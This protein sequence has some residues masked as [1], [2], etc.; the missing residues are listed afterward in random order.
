MRC[1]YCG[2]QLPLLK[3]LT[4]GGEFCSEAH[5]QKYQEEYN[6]LAL[7]RLLQTQNPESDGAGRG[8]L[9]LA[10]RHPALQA[11]RLP[12]RALEAPKSIEAPP[13]STPSFKEGR[14]PD[15][16]LEPLPSNWTPGA[17]RTQRAL[18]PPSVLRTPPPSATNLG[19]NLTNLTNDAPPPANE[20]A[21]PKPLDRNPN[22]T[23]H[24][25]QG[26]EFTHDL[27]KKSFPK[28]DAFSFRPMDPFPTTTPAVAPPPE[29]PAPVVPTILPSPLSAR[30]PMREMPGARE[31]VR[32]PLREPLRE[33]DPPQGTF[34][35]ATVNWADPPPFRKPEQGG[36]QAFTEGKPSSDGWA[37]WEPDIQGG[38]GGGLESRSLLPLLG[39]PGMAGGGGGE[40]PNAVPV[41]EEEDQERIE[42]RKRILENQVKPGEFKQTVPRAPEGL[43]T[44][45]PI[46]PPAAALERFTVTVKAMAPTAN[47]GL[48]LLDAALNGEDLWT[49]WTMTGLAPLRVG[50]TPIAP[51]D[52]ETND[53]EAAELSSAATDANPSETKPLPAPMP[54]LSSNGISTVASPKSGTAVASAKPSEPAAARLPIDQPRNYKAA[55]ALK[56]AAQA[57]AV[58][59]AAAAKPQNDKP[60]T[61]RHEV[62]VDL[63]VLGIEEDEDA[64]AEILA[65]EGESPP[66]SPGVS[67]RSQRRKVAAR[68]AVRELVSL[69]HPP[70]SPAEPKL[71]HT[72]QSQPW[73]QTDSPSIRLSSEPLRPKIVF[74]RVADHAVADLTEMKDSNPVKNGSALNGATRNGA[75]KDRTV[76]VGAATAL[77]MDP[78]AMPHRALAVKPPSASSLASAWSA[79]RLKKNETGAPSSAPGNF[80][81]GTPVEALVSEPP[82]TVV[83]TPRIIATAKTDL[84]GTHIE[85]PKPAQPAAPAAQ[86]QPVERKIESGKAV[87]STPVSAGAKVDVPKPAQ[88]K[89]EPVKAVSAPLMATAKLDA[90][91][92]A[93]PAVAIA[94]AQAVEPKVEPAQ[95]TAEANT[96]EPPAPR[97]AA[98][99]PAKPETE[100][101]AGQTVAAAPNGQT[102]N[103]DS[104][105]LNKVEAMKA[106]EPTTVSAETKPEPNLKPAPSNKKGSNSKS[107]T[108]SK[109]GGGEGKS[110]AKNA[111]GKDHKSGTT[112]NAA[113]LPT[114]EP[115]PENPPFEAPILAVSIAKQGSFWANLPI[116][117]KL[118]IVLAVTAGIG[119]GAWM[120]LK[121]AHSSGSET[122]GGK[123]K[124][125]P[126]PLRAGSSLM[127]NLPGGWSPD[128]GGDLNRK[129]N[130]TISFYRP[131]ANH[132]DYR[133][134]FDGQIDAKGLGWVFRAADPKNYYA[135]KIELVRTGSDSGTALTHFSMVDGIESQKHF[136]P[137]AKPLRTGVSFHVRLDV[138][139]DEFSAYINDE[140]I[141]VW[142]DDR[143]PKGGI[144]LMTDQGER[145]QTR[146]VQIFE[147]VP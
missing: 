51:E 139:G 107:E 31:P 100:Q 5:R 138:R 122:A 105:A 39:P 141:E 84:P 79:K 15:S 78:D 8:E 13:A 88:P 85:A 47:P 71:A 30:P 2:K 86:P 72:F 121:P 23:A 99:P 93:A 89:V 90:P 144:G 80:G 123:Q 17:N 91:K 112:I 27:K 66:G 75:A 42:I 45:L 73:N 53:V 10:S 136:A 128:W 58:E 3:K 96:P 127:M 9:V 98:P 101:P 46:R 129:K 135:Y 55:E 120:T 102:K 19:P 52:I 20:R 62:F 118:A 82:K 77:P 103:S 54:A 1:L 28:R 61:P 18:P 65:R 95:V 6:K 50:L 7:S 116:V 108:G 41:A 29:P 70:A 26:Q 125:P 109:S 32:E 83:S 140:L 134:E 25:P 147:L 40:G 97:A 113:K 114:P 92:V 87:A 44:V 68:E 145:A 133:I 12:L 36:Q 126:K 67:G 14:Q 143:L 117:P 56:S 24:D 34:I 35:L 137:I 33:K 64:D 22:A 57:V 76:S 81:R 142:Q 132:D 16:G 21:F 59:T 131:S 60:S 74:E 146:K 37:R 48:H 119:G 110:R 11:G 130:R 69:P 43:T 4:G 115:L 124:A 94:Q 106:V 63:S 104:P 111:D 49:G 38:P